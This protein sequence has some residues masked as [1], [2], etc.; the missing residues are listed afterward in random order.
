MICIPW[1]VTR[2]PIMRIRTPSKSIPTAATA[3]TTWALLTATATI[4]K[5][6]ATRTSAAKRRLAFRPLMTCVSSGLSD[7]L[8]RAIAPW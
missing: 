1:L 8:V 2:T 6:K 3:P 5:M 4:A 7:R